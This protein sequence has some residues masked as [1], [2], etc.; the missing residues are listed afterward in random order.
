MNTLTV[1]LTG[2]ASGLLVLLG[3]IHAA[4]R[5]RNI[6]RTLFILSA[7]CAAAATAALTW[8]LASKSGEEVMGRL[9]VHLALVIFAPALII[10]FFIF[11]GRDEEKGTLRRLLPGMVTFGALLAAA[12]L[13]VPV[14]LV[15]S[16]FQLVEGGGLW[17]IGVTGTGQLLAI[18]SLAGN[19]LVMHMFE[20]TYRAS[21]IPDKVKLKYPLLGLILA[22][23]MNFIMMTRL[24]LISEVDNYFISLSA[25]GLIFFC[26]TLLFAG[27]RYPVFEVRTPRDRKASQSVVTVVAA[28]LYLLAFAIVSWVSKFVGMPYERF[29]LLV[30]SAFSVFIVLAV[31][32]SGRARRRL[33]VFINDNFR[34]GLYN[35]R[36]EWRQYAR[37]MA[38]SSTIEELVSN[39]VSA[40]CQTMMVR[41][42]M[43]YT[44]VGMRRRAEYGLE[45][46]EADAVS[47][48]EI[49]E[50]FSGE[51]LVTDGLK[52]WMRS[53]SFLIIG[54]RAR[55]FIALGPKEF[56]R[57]WS[58]EDR[59]FLSTITD[60]VALTLENLLMEERFLE[61]KQLESFNRFASFVIHDLKNTV[62]MLSLTAEN[63]RDN[64]Q[65]RDFQEDAIDTV[66][67]SVQKMRRLID[68]LN[69]HKAPAAISRSRTDV[70]AVASDR[71]AALQ[72]LA[73]KKDVVIGFEPEGGAEAYVDPSA[74]SRILENIVLNAI[75]AVPDGGRID[76]VTAVREGSLV[77]T[78]SDDGPGFDPEYLENGL[79]RPFMSTKKNGLGVGLV[80]CKSLTEAHGGS[81]S[82][83]SPPGGGSVVTAEIPAER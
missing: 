77:I 64:I 21:G 45:S 20:N 71:I 54:G 69:A 80:L 4:S 6:Q 18:L 22:S 49:I 30:A 70:A 34:P 55:G 46:E 9:Q 74:M 56:G 7:L 52:G 42:G 37:L 53:V 65:D 58:E 16:R 59:D 24:V 57:H 39:T 15:V 5:T 43:I 60:Q 14:E 67:R 40:L 61:S 76:V 8:A 79:F 19:V 82:V 10:P 11:F 13:L 73:S 3:A 68:S 66:E 25:L 33:K 78:V 29:G 62:G 83:S 28:G 38:S 63:A 12:A 50:M 41:Q 44:D 75:E 1:I 31:L 2:A 51:Q 32:V 81:I 72:Q 17:R 36:R 23:V 27:W 26:L 47:A 48:G 35:Y